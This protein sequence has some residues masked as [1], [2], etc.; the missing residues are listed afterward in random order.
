[1]GETLEEIKRA[2]FEVALTPGELDR[3]KFIQEA[4]REFYQVECDLN[5]LEG[6]E[7]S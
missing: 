1:M 6:K 4:M 5:S 3:L 7:D 2:I